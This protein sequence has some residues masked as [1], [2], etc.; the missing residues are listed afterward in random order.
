MRKYNTVFALLGVTLFG[1]ATLF[2]GVS[3]AETVVR[4]GDTISVGNNQVVVDDFYGLGGTAA[5]SGAVAGDAHIVSGSLT[6]NA[7]IGADL[8]AVSGTVQVHGAIADDLRVVGGEVTLADAVGGDVFVLGGVL[9]VLSTAT[10]EG[11]I[12]FFG[13]ELI[14]EGPVGGS[15]FG[16]GETVRLDA[17][18]GGDV[19]VTV[20][21]HLTLGDRAEVLGEI[22]VRGGEL[23]RSQGAVVVGDIREDAAEPTG[24]N[25]MVMA[26]VPLL[27]VL[28]GSL[29]ALVVFRPQLSRLVGEA[30]VSYG[31]LGLIGLAVFVSVPFAALVFLVSVLGALIGLALLAVYVLFLIAAWVLAGVILGTLL[32]QVVQKE[33]HVTVLTVLLGVTAL[34]LLCFVPFIGPL[35]VLALLL[36]ALGTLSRGVYT[37]LRG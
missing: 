30:R 37:L 13:G 35:V 23:V 29:L 3:H 1:A 17:S 31:V 10:I 21:E 12:F 6:V 19:A 2:A 26:L 27:A 20:A 9:R 33:E 32:M 15:V 34:H 22:L 8:A 7:P 11:D 16:T 28:F 4:S 5:I 24:G 25:V 36:V 14:V 18:V